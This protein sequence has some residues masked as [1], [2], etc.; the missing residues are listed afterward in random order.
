MHQINSS[1]T[2]ALYRCR[3]LPSSCCRSLD[4]CTTCFG[5]NPAE[6]TRLSSMLACHQGRQTWNC[7]QLWLPSTQLIKYN[8]FFCK[9]RLSITSVTETSAIFW[10]DDTTLTD[11]NPKSVPSLKPTSKMYEDEQISLKLTEIQFTTR[12]LCNE[13]GNRA[14]KL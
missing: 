7:K 1:F 9:H 14:I 4:E 2:I 6:F 10:A 12:P 8:N 13:T 5:L 11:P 3:V